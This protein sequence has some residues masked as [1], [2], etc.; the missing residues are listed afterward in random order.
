MDDMSFRVMLFDKTKPTSA[1]TSKTITIRR[2]E[3]PENAIAA[4]SDVER[5]FLL[6]SGFMLNEL[7]SLNKVFIWCLKSD[8]DKDSPKIVGNA[9]VIQSMVYARILAGKVCEGF[10]SLGNT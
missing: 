3:L 9:N 8:A 7:N 4:L 6:L 2:V 10:Q 1:M 5:E